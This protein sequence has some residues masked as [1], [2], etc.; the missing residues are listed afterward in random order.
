MSQERSNPAELDHFDL[1]AYADG[2]VSVGETDFVLA[3][4]HEL[5]VEVALDS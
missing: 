3:V 2:E 5:G 1:M 4:A